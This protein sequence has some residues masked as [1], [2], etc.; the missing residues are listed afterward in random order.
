MI[1][2]AQSITVGS[3]LPMGSACLH[4]RSDG[5]GMK[6]ASYWSNEAIRRLRYLNPEI[7]L[8]SSATNGWI[9]FH[10]D[11]FAKLNTEAKLLVLIR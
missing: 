2:G 8:D 1:L 3:A 11:E 5:L 9:A 6:P 7:V 10:I 4:S